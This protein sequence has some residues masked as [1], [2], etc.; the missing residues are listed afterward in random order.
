MTGWFT[1]R[2]RSAT[3]Y[4]ELRRS[5]MPSSGGSAVARD[6]LPRSKHPYPPLCS[7]P[8]LPMMQTQ[9]A[10]QNAH[11]GIGVLRRREDFALRTFHFAQDDRVEG[12]QDEI[13]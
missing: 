1:C 10:R 2:I 8:A 4:A 13:C 12:N 5:V 9:R 7:S 6:R 11:A 3:S